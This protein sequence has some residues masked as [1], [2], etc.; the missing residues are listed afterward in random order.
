M[1]LIT[2]THKLSMLC[3]CSHSYHLM[4]QSRA[5]FARPYSISVF[6]KSS[7]LVFD[8]F[9]TNVLYLFKY[10]CCRVLSSNNMLILNYVN[11]NYN[12]G[13]LENWP[14]AHNVMIKVNFWLLGV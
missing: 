9:V 14:Q 8:I 13:W 6:C 7:I 4:S 12:S 2:H 5:Y 10:T 1:K 11:L 3:Q